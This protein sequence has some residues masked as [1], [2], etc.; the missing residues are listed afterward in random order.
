MRCIYNILL[1]IFT[2]IICWLSRN[3]DSWLY[4]RMGRKIRLFIDGQG[5]TLQ[6]IYDC[7]LCNG[8]PTYWFHASSL[9]EYGIARPVILE[10]R[11]QQECNIL[12][13]FFSSTGIEALKDKGVERTGV[14]YVAYLPLDCKKNVK[15]FLDKVQ[16]TKAIFIKSEYWLNYLDELQLR[17]IPTYLVS[18]YIK[19]S[20]VFFKWY[21]KIYREALQVYQNIFTQDTESQKLLEE[22]GIMNS[23]VMGDPLYDNAIVN[24]NT[25]YKN[26]VIERFVATASEGVFIAG[27]IDTK[28]D[29][30]L[31]AALI[32]NHPEHKFIIVPHE[33]DKTHVTK[34]MFALKEK[35]ILHSECT[36]E[37][38]YSDIQTLIIDYV[39]DLAKIYRYGKLTYVGGGFTPLLH[40]VIEPSVYGLPV[41]FGPKINRKAAPQLMIKHGIGTM[42]TSA[43]ELDKWF[44]FLFNNDIALERIRKEAKQF[45]IASSG[46]TEGVVKSILFSDEKRKK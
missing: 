24:G 28:H 22:L 42:V 34:V 9:G 5:T 10:M 43:K 45:V 1:N 46:K 7:S 8:L 30:E 36:E 27:S 4:K 20:S 11:K 32:N 41:A 6:E 33:V 35:N 44:C 19:P 25:P 21:G 13:T 3:H 39:G 2:D 18:A 26:E 40:S 12:L 31:T 23:T 14:D 15:A 17:H 38:D 29:L 37:T 16:P